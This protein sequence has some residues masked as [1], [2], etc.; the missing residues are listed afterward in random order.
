MIVHHISMYGRF[1]ADRLYSYFK[2]CNTNHVHSVPLLNGRKNHLDSAKS[3]SS[4]SE[5]DIAFLTRNLGFRISDLLFE[6]DI[7]LVFEIAVGIVL[8]LTNLLFHPYQ[9]ISLFQFF[10]IEIAYDLRRFTFC[11]STI[12]FAILLP[13][14]NL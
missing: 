6:F 2:Y 1:I 11:L 5:H 14:S 13:S 12:I 4:H 8:P 7:C 10:A 3:C 9:L